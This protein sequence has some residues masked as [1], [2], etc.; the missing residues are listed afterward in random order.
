MPTVVGILTIMSRK[1]F[2]HGGSK[3]ILCVSVS[4]VI[5]SAISAS[6]SLPSSNLS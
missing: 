1:N 2:M 6:E 3:T 5:A 4:N